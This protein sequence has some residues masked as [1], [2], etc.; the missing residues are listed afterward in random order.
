MRIAIIGAGAIGC[1]YGAYLSRNNEVYMLCRRQKVVDAINKEG[2][3]VFE[4]DGRKEKYTNVHACLSGECKAEIDLILVIVKGMDTKSA[5]EANHNIIKANTMVMTLQ[6]GGGN[7]RKLAEFVP[8]EKV[9]IGTTR[10]NSVNLDNGNIRHSGS[11]PTYI[12]S[13]DRKTDLNGIKQVFE[14][15]GLETIVSDNIQ[16]IIWSKL[17]FNLSINTF[18]AITKSPFGFAIE[19]DYAWNFVEKLI[20]EAIDVAE[21]D[22]QHFSYL[23]ILNSV[24]KTCE[25][26]ATGFSSMSQ[27]VMNCRKTEVDA[28]NGFVVDRANVHNVPTPYNN[29]VINLIHSIEGTYKE[30]IKP[31]IKYSTGEVILKQGEL[32]PNLYKIMQGNVSL[33]T[34]YGTENEYLIGVCS[35]G[36]CFG[37]YSCFSGRPSTYSV[38]ADED[39][40]V[41]EIPKS[42]LHNFIS[43]NPKN[44]E[45]I[46]GSMAKQIALLSKHIE[47]LKNEK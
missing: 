27:D 29:F 4:A 21:A 35:L 46:F 2:L 8:M 3:T 37:E 14:E 32:N 41:M 23:E 22:G 42:D 7:D 34:D 40:I 16:R 25:S 9:I 26:V 44:A 28:I 43:I 30:Q 31:Q 39:T 11:G 15:A 18:T 12:G 5:M 24:H 1:L 47:M 17:F 45:E 20:C 10:H 33:Y 38:V 6:N 19:N 36:K 13:N